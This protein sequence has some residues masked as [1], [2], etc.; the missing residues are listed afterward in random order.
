[1]QTRVHLCQKQ[2]AYDTPVEEAGHEET[3]EP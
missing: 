1:M 2:T 3:L